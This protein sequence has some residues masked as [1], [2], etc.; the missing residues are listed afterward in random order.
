MIQICHC[1]LR[2]YTK[3]T[4]LCSRLCDSR[5]VAALA[6]VPVDEAGLA[7]L[8]VGDPIEA[9]EKCGLI[10]RIL[11]Q[12]IGA[13]TAKVSQG[14]PGGGGCRRDGGLWRESCRNRTE[15]HRQQRLME[16]KRRTSERRQEQ[17]SPIDTL[18]WLT[19]G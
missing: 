11:I 15:K 18:S 5:P 13:T 16:A 2:H 7:A 14:V 4:V 6:A 3:F 9:M 12:A 10:G 8:D 19:R 17:Q 1:V